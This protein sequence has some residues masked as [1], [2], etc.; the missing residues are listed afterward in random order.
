M[1]MATTVNIHE[2]KTNLS[3][4]LVRVANGEE[5]IISKSG[6]PIAKLVSISN[7]LKRR[8]PGSAK[9][10]IFIEKDFDSPLPE[11]ILKAFEE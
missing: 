3:K 9:G 2:A 5:I 6:K 4:L 10:K 7:K 11:E 8:S 1:I